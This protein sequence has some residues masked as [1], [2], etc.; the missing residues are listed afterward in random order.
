MWR[1]IHDAVFVVENRSGRR[2]IGAEYVLSQP[3]DSTI[4]A[5]T[6]SVVV[7][8][9]PKKRYRQSHLGHSDQFMMDPNVL[10]PIHCP[11]IRE[12]IVEMQ[13]QRR[14]P[15]LVGLHRRERPDGYE[16]GI[17]QASAHGSR[18]RAVL[19]R[20]GAGGQGVA[21]VGNPADTSGRPDLIVCAVS[22]DERL[23]QYPDAPTFKEL[24]IEGLDNEVMWRGFSMKKG[25]PP[26]A[27]AWL[28]DLVEKVSQDPEWK[29]F[30]EEQA[31]KVVAYRTDEFTEIVKNNVE[32]AIKYFK[33]YG[34]IK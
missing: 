6:T 21:Y 10:S 16:H 25:S 29:E 19:P 11:S 5:P 22:S 17:K 9:S 26:E 3:A 13:S 8:S 7:S 14:K 4:F 30:F 1:K 18:M 28:Q 33:E 23:P 34:I 31:I 32:D 27:V 24:G 12:D 20:G 2:T 15:D